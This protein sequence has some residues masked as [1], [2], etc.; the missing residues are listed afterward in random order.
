[1]LSLRHIGLIVTRRFVFPSLGRCRAASVNKHAMSATRMLFPSAT[2]TSYTYLPPCLVRIQGLPKRFVLPE[3]SKNSLISHKSS[4]FSKK[5]FGKFREIS[6]PK[7]FKS[8]LRDFQDSNH[9]L[10]ITPLYLTLINTFRIHA[11]NKLIFQQCH[12]KKLLSLYHLVG[13]LTF[14]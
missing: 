2:Y 8:I 13:I 14:T 3:T 7:S 1:M 5:Q 9:V 11:F 12:R 10:F 6:L 4:K